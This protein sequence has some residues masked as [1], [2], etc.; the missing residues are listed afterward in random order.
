MNVLTYQK[1]IPWY[2]ATGL[3]PAQ[4]HIRGASGLCCPNSSSPSS[5]DL[6]DPQ[7]RDTEYR[8]QKATALAPFH[9]NHCI[10]QDG[11]ISY[12]EGKVR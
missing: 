4:R 8:G 5:Q 3:K 6:C 2:D 7:A 10:L 11:V 9:A 12:V 1:S